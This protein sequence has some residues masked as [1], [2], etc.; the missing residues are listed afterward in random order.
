MKQSATSLYG[1]E[2]YEG[3]GIDLIHELSKELGFEYNITS[4]D[5]GANG[6]RDNK[7]G[8]W[9]GMIGKVMY[10]VSVKYVVK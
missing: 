5:D 4:Q 8:R 9:D 7:T 10:K 1:N 3:F 2:R 6:S